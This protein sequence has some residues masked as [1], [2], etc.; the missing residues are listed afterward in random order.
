MTRSLVQT[1][2]DHASGGSIKGHTNLTALAKSSDGGVTTITMKHKSDP[3]VAFTALTASESALT[4]ALQREEL[5]A[6]CG[7]VTP[8]VGLGFPL[9]RRLR[10]AGVEID[11]SNPAKL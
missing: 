8:A 7:F 10:N 1:P 6:A 3:G 4:L 11:V 2:V 9:V 5:P